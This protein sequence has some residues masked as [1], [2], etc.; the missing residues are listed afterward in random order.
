MKN[1]QLKMKEAFVKWESDYFHAIEFEQN[2]WLRP[3]PDR[4]IIW[5]RLINVHFMLVRDELK[6]RKESKQIV[7]S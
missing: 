2:E 1:Y 6:E 5:H 4:Y 3:Q 7:E